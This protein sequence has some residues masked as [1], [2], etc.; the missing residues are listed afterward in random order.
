[1]AL[2]LALAS[3]RHLLHPIY[4]NLRRLH[5]H[6][7]HIPRSLAHPRPE[8]P[9]C[10]AEVRL[11]WPSVAACPPPHILIAAAGARAATAPL[12]TASLASAPPAAALPSAALRA[13]SLLA[14]TLFVAAAATTVPLPAVKCRPAL[15]II[16]LAARFS[17]THPCLRG[18]HAYP[19]APESAFA[20]QWTPLFLPLPLHVP[21]QA[22]LTAHHH[23]N[24][25]THARPL[26]RLLGAPYGSLP[27]L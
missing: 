25:T 18:N 10:R 8:T 15:T 4:H 6:L 7:H 2:Q 24:F 3:H 19:T 23:I 17:R 16:L 5:G 26:A 1:M 11:L 21:R 20:R 13:T 22:L 9:L 12:T 14:P 27:S